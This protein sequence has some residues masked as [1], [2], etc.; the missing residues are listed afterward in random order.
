MNESN[1]L[2]IIGINVT[3]LAITMAALGIF[4]SLIA[5]RKLGVLDRIESIQR[6]VESEFPVKW[7]FPGEMAKD[8]YNSDSDATRQDL[9]QKLAVLAAGSQDSSLAP[10]NDSPRMGELIITSLL[11]LV[12]H[13]PFARVIEKLPDGTNILR[14]RPL[15]EDQSAETYVKW[16]RDIQ[17][18]LTAVAHLDEN[19]RAMMFHRV[20]SFQKAADASP[21]ISE[22][23][24]RANDLDH[25]LDE[26]KR[27]LS[28]LEAKKPLTQ[29]TGE[30]R[31]KMRRKETLTEYA[32]DMRFMAGPDYEK[33]FDDIF[34]QFKKA[35]NQLSSLSG[36]LQ[37][38]RYYD[39]KP[40]PSQKLLL[41]TSVALTI[42]LGILLPM[43]QPFFSLPS[44]KEYVY[45]V[46]GIIPIL[47]HIVTACTAYWIMRF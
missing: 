28:L 43:C 27:E 2:T 36:D 1:L 15:I 13:Y 31:N 20:V 32:R 34:K 21:M 24:K 11:S 12:H 10:L 42:C 4:T 18:V 14:K 33:A 46:Y 37:K 26:L 25:E 19:Y 22:Q 30:E 6:E 3:I 23:R 39:S 7:Y 41:I 38:L 45:L 16:A 5:E 35:R 47:L 40:S 17:N 9:L 8:E 44:S 29:Y